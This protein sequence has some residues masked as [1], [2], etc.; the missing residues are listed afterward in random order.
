MVGSWYVTHATKNV[1]WIFTLPFFVFVLQRKT[2]GSCMSKHEN[3]RYVVCRPK[4]MLNAYAWWCNDSCKMWCW[5]MIMDKCRN[6]MFIM[7]PWRDAYAM[8]DMNAFTDMRARKIISSYLCIR[9]RSAPCVQLRRWYGPFG[10]PWQKTRPTYN[11]CVMTWCRCAKAQQGDVH[12]MAISS[13]N[14]TAK[15]YMTFGLYAWQCLK[16]TLRVYFVP[17]F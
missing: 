2:Q 15:A 8:H 1:V 6:D 16:G 14:H 11:A 5:N 12:S 7:M 3:K 9:G 10:F 17:L 13:N 4:S